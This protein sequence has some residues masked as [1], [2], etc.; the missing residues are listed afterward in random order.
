M[1]NLYKPTKSKMAIT[2]SATRAILSSAQTLHPNALRKLG[3]PV[4]APEPAPVP[5]VS[6]WRDWV[7]AET[8]YWPHDD[9]SPTSPGRDYSPTTPRCK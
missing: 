2:R 3:V 4:P 5:Q 6:H 7:L 9:Y 8:P 1:S